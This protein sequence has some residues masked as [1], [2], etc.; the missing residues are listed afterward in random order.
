VP[1]HSCGTPAEQERRAAGHPDHPAVE[2]AATVI[3]HVPGH[4]GHV[5]LLGDD[6]V[7][8]VPLG[9]AVD[10]DYGDRRVP[11]AVERVLAALVRG[12]VRADR[13]SQGVVE[14]N[15]PGEPFTFARQT[16]SMFWLRWKTL[17][18]S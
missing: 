3:A 2:T 17:S 18:G 8:V 1:V 11:P 12:E 7:A 15:Q 16:G 5:D 6:R 4:D 9:I 14:G 10:Q 13:G